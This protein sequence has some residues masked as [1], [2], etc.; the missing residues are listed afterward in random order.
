MQT[1]SILCD[2]TLCMGNYHL[3]LT[4]RYVILLKYTHW[5]IERILSENT[6]LNKILLGAQSSDNFSYWSN[7]LNLLNTIWAYWYAVFGFF[8]EYKFWHL[9]TS[10]GPNHLFFLIL[11]KRSLKCCT[12]VQH[13][14]EH[15]NYVKKNQTIWS[16]RCAHMPKFVLPDET[17]YRISKSPDGVQKIQPIRS[18]RKFTRTLCS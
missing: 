14:R 15:L 3:I 5:L 12:R 16:G 17:K 18:I 1:T 6:T 7:W 8:W 2:Q 11:F 9:R 10:P 13:Y 4:C